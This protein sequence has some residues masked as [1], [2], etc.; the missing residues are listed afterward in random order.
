MGAYKCKVHCRQVEHDTPGDV[1]P[2]SDLAHR[3]EDTIQYV[4]DAHEY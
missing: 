4:A 3:V 2:R 1:S